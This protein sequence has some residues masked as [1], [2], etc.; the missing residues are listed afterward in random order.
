MSNTYLKF[1]HI[2]TAFRNAEHIEKPATIR[3]YM[4]VFIMA[5]T[6][7]SISDGGQRLRHYFTG[8]SDDDK[9][10]HLS[11]FEF[12]A[13]SNTADADHCYRCF[14]SVGLSVCTRLNSAS[15]CKNG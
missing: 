13:A 2:T 6:L 9:L 7:Q 1:V 3:S 14:L 5:I 15:L 8:S 11:S 12:L 10:R 4:C